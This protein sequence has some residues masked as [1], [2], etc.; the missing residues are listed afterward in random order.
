MESRLTN[1]V[2]L[3]AVRYDQATGLV[4]VVVQDSYSH[5]VLMVAYANREA[6]KRTLATGQSWFWSRSRQ[7]YWHKGAS[8]GHVQTVDDV[9]IDCDG[10]TVLY[11]VT[12]RGPACHTGENSC[13]YRSIT[14][15]EIIDFQPHEEADTPSATKQLDSDGKRATDDDRRSD[16]SKLD[17]IASLWQT[18]QSRFVEMPEG[19]YTS[20]LF[21]H[22][23]EKVGKKVGEE[24]V[25][26]ALAALRAELTGEKAFVASES[27]DLLYHLLVLWCAVD[28]TPDDVFSVLQSRD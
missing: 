26:V 3:A 12:P 4:P 21:R 14:H 16:V 27:A 1:T 23:A 13:F 25:E 7:S 19:S 8:S 17:V 5:E 15:H 2:D 28:V 18:I 24:A 22:G 9:R 20:Y 10:D 6:L 11:L